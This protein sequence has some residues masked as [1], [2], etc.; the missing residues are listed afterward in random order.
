MDV[1]SKPPKEPESPC[2]NV[3]VINSKTGYCT[4]CFRTLREVRDWMNAT[5][6]EKSL[7]LENVKKRK[8]EIQ[9]SK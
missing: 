7:I 2:I 8:D 3:C 4:G 5:S 6:L 1:W 9:S